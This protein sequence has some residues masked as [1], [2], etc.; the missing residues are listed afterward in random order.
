MSQLRWDPLLQEWVTYAPQRQERTFLPPAEWC[1]LCPTKPGGFPTEV[2][3]AS[4]EIVVFE[5]RFPSY[6]LD[7]PVPDEV[8]SELT[9]TAPGRGICEVVLYS[10]NHNSTLAQ[11]EERRIRQL[12]EVWADRY[13]ELGA[14]DVVKYVFIFENKG[15][16]IGVTLHHPHGQIYAYPFIP[17][18][19]ARELR[20]AQAYRETHPGQCL[21]CSLL[22]QEQRD[23]RRM[24]VEGEHFAAFVPFFAHFPYEMHIYAK[25]CA[26]SIMHLERAER[27]DLAHVLKQV[28]VSYDALWNMSLPYMMVMHQAPTDEEDYEGVAH[29][30]VEFYPPNRTREKLKYLAGSETGAGAF[31]VDV[32]PEEAVAQL[33]AAH[34]RAKASSTE[35]ASN[36]FQG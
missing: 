9:P 24:V 33:R 7:A 13:Q 12:V 10:A 16:A 36:A 2:P 5:N 35:G 31:I 23:G 32:M 1:P 25:R 4:Y 18:R 34:E 14:L 22:S 28:L 26:P 20:A 19:P 21:H 11:M 8:G 29:F 15:E 27:Q 3:R 30:H 6:T 17:S